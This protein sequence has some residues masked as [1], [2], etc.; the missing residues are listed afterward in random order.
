[1]LLPAA[2]PVAIV[3]I[4]V[5]QLRSQ[6]GLI[7][8]CLTADPSNFPDCKNS[9]RSV[10]RSVAAGQRSIRFEGLAQGNWAGAIIHDENS[11]GKLDTVMGIPREGFGFTRNPKIGFGPPKFD[12][13]RF[14]VD[15]ALKP[16]P[17][18]MRYLL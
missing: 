10:S 2:S 4:D 17:V 16:Q 13:A 18:R 8:I 3:E 12:A 14:P 15:D 9:A 11:N 7:R 6:K 1:M 5:Q